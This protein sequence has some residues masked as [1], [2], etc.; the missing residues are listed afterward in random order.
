MK[1]IFLAFI[2]TIS[3]L[4][5]GACQKDSAARHLAG[6]SPTEVYAAAYEAQQSKNIEVLKGLLTA[7]TIEQMTAGGT[8]EGEK[9]KI[10]ND[11]LTQMAES[12]A[13]PRPEV[14]NEVI[15][16]E[17]ASIEI[18]SGENWETVSFKKENGIWKIGGAGAKP[19]RKLE[20]DE[21][22]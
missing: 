1:K 11:V 4:T 8:T 3:V 21:K 15:D 6:K 19:K 12:S 20:S 13:L 22:S 14:R 10:L 9:N 16:G 2:F 5:V 18:S 17:N 7:E